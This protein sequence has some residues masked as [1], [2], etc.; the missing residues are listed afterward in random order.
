MY[1][2][3]ADPQAE[4]IGLDNLSHYLVD[5][6]EGVPTIVDQVSAWMEKRGLREAQSRTESEVPA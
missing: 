4:Y 3:S 2:A 1:T 5:Q 6:P